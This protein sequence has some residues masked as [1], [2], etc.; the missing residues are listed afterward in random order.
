MLHQNVLNRLQEWLVTYLLHSQRDPRLWPDRQA[1]PQFCMVASERLISP[2]RVIL[3]EN[4]PDDKLTCLNAPPLDPGVASEPVQ[5]C[6][7][8]NATSIEFGPI[9][10]RGVISSSPFFLPLARLSR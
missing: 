5:R 2:Y 6:M 8:P 10:M 4:G 1:R 3:R 7:E 9:A